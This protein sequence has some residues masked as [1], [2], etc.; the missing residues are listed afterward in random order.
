MTGKMIEA[1]D[2]GAVECCDA[3]LVT[4]TTG[5]PGLPGATYAIAWL[6]LQNPE[7]F[8]P[9]VRERHA[10]NMLRFVHVSG[11]N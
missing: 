10:A 4:C 8:T 11:R 2:M 6:P 9:E 1:Y 3:S 5:V 7:S